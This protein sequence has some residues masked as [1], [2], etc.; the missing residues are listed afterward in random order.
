MGP[1]YGAGATT[2]AIPPEHTGFLLDV[3]KRGC[4]VSNS[5]GFNQTRVSNHENA[6]Y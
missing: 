2:L 5:L 4:V 1:P 6:L 3:V